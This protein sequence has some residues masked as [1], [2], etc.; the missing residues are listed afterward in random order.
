MNSHVLQSLLAGWLSGAA[1]GLGVTA[2]ALVWVSRRPAVMRRLPLQARLPVLGIVV[3]NAMVFGLT[4]IGLVAGAVY[5]G[6]SVD[7]GG[8]RFPLVL[9]GIVVAAAA[10]YAFVRGPRASEAPAV[11]G[12]LVV[13]GLAF[14]GMLPWLAG[15]DR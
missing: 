12:A 11:V 5:H 6:T 13:C 14:G 10:L 1:A 9:A 8:G 4:L 2:V 3:A 7:A 15:I